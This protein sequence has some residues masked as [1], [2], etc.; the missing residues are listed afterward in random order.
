MRRLTVGVSLVLA[1]GCG[2]RTEPQA[3]MPTPIPTVVADL[4]IGGAVR[5]VTEAQRLWFDFTTSG[6]HPHC[7]DV[8]TKGCITEAERDRVMVAFRAYVASRPKKKLSSTDT[9]PA[10]IAMVVASRNLVVAIADAIERQ[11]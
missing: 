3:A 1:V 8:V 4:T 10:P 2:T 6:K 5:D 7:T 9:R 11:R